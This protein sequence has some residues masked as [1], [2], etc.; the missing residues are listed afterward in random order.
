MF[1]LGKSALSA[2]LCNERVAAIEHGAGE[3]RRGQA[4]AGGRSDALGRVGGAAVAPSNA[5][6]RGTPAALTKFH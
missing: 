2:V 4:R 1:Y 3:G 6:R 5:V